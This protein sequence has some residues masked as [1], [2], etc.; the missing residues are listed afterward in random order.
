MAPSAPKKDSKDKDKNKHS[1]HH[2][3]DGSSSR[4][5]RKPTREEDK[6]AES[7]SRK[8]TSHHFK[9]SKSSK[10]ESRKKPSTSHSHHHSS[11]PAHQDR[12]AKPPMNYEERPEKSSRHDKPEPM[13]KFKTAFTDPK[14]IK[15]AEKQTR[16]KTLTPDE[17]EKQHKWAQE[18]LKTHG[19]CPAGYKWWKY[20]KGVDQA[21]NH[22]EG[23]RCYAGN[24]LVT[25]EL[26]AEAKGGCYMK[27]RLIVLEALRAA[28]AA[29]NGFGFP[30]PSGNQMM[31]PQYPGALSP[32]IP[33]YGGGPGFQNRPNNPR[34]QQ[35]PPQMPLP[36]TS[37]KPAP[38][39]FRIW[40][41]PD[42]YSANNKDIMLQ[43]QAL[44][45]QLNP[46]IVPVTAVNPV[47]DEFQQ[48]PPSWLLNGD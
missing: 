9:E 38:S 1:R 44:P 25:H 3:T 33:G 43:K 14:D 42:Y 18:K 13:I 10:H 4:H 40:Y 30:G 2:T 35:F 17:L 19:L 15:M 46:H 39:G 16:M 31:P 11:K 7:S 34:F 12:H 36:Q 5:H 6:Y 28:H 37:A 41:G 47:P 32:M 27:H 26:L 24:H 23:Y 29:Q 45:G 8:E 21:G 20:N 22:L 48:G